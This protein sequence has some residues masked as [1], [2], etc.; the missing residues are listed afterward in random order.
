MRIFKLSSL[1]TFASALLASASAGTVIASEKGK[2][3]HDAEFYVLEAQHGEQ[4]AAD[5][6]VVDRRLAAFREKNNGKS[7]NILYILIDDI[8]FGD[9]GIPELNAVRGYK[10]PAINKFSGEGM[11]F[12]RMCTEKY[13][14]PNG[15]QSELTNI[16][17]SNKADPCYKVAE[18]VYWFKNTKINDALPDP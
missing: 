9:L 10:T 14:T 12:V 4:W 2:I 7:P 16:S 8:G 3:V 17:I 11:R 6:K 5:D 15:E 1:L 13:T 18:K